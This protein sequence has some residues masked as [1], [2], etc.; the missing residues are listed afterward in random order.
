MRLEKSKFSLLQNKEI[1]A[2]L[3]GDK[4]FGM[5]EIEGIKTDITISMPYLSGPR[6]CDISNR[7]GLPATYCW[8][9]GSLSRWQYLNDLLE[10]CIKNGQE[11]SLFSFLFSKEQFCD[12]LKG[13]LPKYIDLAYTQIV[14]TV[15]AEIN[16]I[17]Y[18]GGN[19]LTKT[20]G[21][22]SVQEIEAAVTVTTPTIDRIDRVYVANML[23]RAFEDVS[24]GNYDS[25]L[26]KSRSLIEEVFAFVIEKKGEEPSDKGN[27]FNLYAQVKKLYG[28]KL[29]NDADTKIDDLISG[30]GK[31]LKAI[32][33]I[34]N[35]ASDAH[36]LG[37]KRIYVEEHQARFIVNSSATIADF[38]LSVYEK[39]AQL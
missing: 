16:S 22:F 11:S 39:D 8:G 34:R 4:D 1:L 30:L 23:Q 27:I 25:A 9:G 33:E 18:F 31:I 12:K 24:D 5:L 26:T 17:L 19:E 7:F 10:H 21:V 29:E 38:V 35:K 20:G 37:G 15:I 36:G 3:D 2:I 32:A 28:K 14:S 6:L 13:N